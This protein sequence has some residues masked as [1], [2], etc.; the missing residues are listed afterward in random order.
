YKFARADVAVAVAVPGGLVT[1]IIR[2]AG[3]KGLGAI[4]GEMQALAEKAKSGKLAPEDYSGGSIS[5]SNLGMYGIKQFE[6][7]I[8][9][10]QAAILAVGAAE[11]RPVVKDGALAVATVMEAT[12]SC[13]HRAIDGATGAALLTAVKGILEQPLRLML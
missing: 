12:L 9:P 8:N 11:A 7:V 2:D 4:A 3:S 1:P 5:L 6:A 10:P 13:D